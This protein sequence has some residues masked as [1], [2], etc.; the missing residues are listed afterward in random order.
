M[1]E[2]LM[3][4]QGLAGS[5]MALIALAAVFIALPHTWYHQ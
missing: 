2:F 1:F 5:M 3:K 4:H